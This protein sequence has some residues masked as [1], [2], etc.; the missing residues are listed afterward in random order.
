MDDIQRCR[1]G[2][3]TIKFKLQNID[4]QTISLKN[5]L[6]RT[7][8]DM[9][10][11]FET[12]NKIIYDRDISLRNNVEKFFEDNAKRLREFKKNLQIKADN[13]NDVCSETVRVM[14]AGNFETLGEMKS[15]LRLR[16]SSLLD[17]FDFRDVNISMLDFDPV[18]EIT[19]LTNDLKSLLKSN[20]TTDM[21]KQASNQSTTNQQGKFSK[22][23]PVNN[24]LPHYGKLSRKEQEQE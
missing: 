24:I 5:S 9:R 17:E 8:K 21:S 12:I 19:S 3:N 6:D 23:L 11:F 16:Q 14:Q 20:S 18:N 10:S 1:D 2:E 7:Q 22:Y 4:L 13:I 15:L